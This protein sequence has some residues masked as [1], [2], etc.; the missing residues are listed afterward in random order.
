MIG[1][2]PVKGYEGIMRD[3]KSGA[4]INIGNEGAQ[5]SANRARMTADKV[6]LEADQGRLN[7]VEVNLNKLE[8]DVS[9]IKMMLKQL[10]ER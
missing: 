6:R 10:I 1:M 2:T 9:E 8:R 3:N 4:I 5:H 7:K